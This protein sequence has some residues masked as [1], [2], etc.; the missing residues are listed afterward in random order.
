MHLTRTFDFSSFTVLIYAES[1]FARQLL[2]DMC[3][4]LRFQAVISKRDYTAS[5]DSFK[6][7]PV[8]LVIGDIGSDEG[9]RFLKAVR[10][11]ET[12][13]NALIPFIATSI[14]TS[15]DCV[16]RARDSGATEFL[17]L[18]LSAVTL[19]ERIIYV[20]EHPRVFV[21]TAGYLGPDR[22]RKQRPFNG[23]DRRQKTPASAESPAEQAPETPTEQG[24]V[25]T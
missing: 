2:T 17:K 21:K 4:A 1:E 11:I 12:S 18:P 23:P 9:L 7:H 15:V 19:I 3:R 5:W 13:P 10:N 20:I 6:S 25:S 22:R 14:S 16:A 24:S 8:D